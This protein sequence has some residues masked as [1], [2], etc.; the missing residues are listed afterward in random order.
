MLNG[1]MCA[2]ERTMCC[3]LENYQTAEGVTVPEVLRPYMGGIDFIP[4][5]QKAT[6][7]FFK[8]K[9]EEAKREAE[10]AKKGGKKDAKPKAAKAAGAEEK[11][12]APKAEVAKAA[13]PA[14]SAAAQATVMVPPQPKFTVNPRHDSLEV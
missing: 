12:S 7:N 8:A 3:V 9:E 6:A 1:T 11:K 13:A 14:K 4:Y 10:R 5:D 2:T